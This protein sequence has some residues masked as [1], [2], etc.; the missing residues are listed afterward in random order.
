MTG[1]VRTD[2]LDMPTVKSII[3]ESPGSA[4]NLSFFRADKAISI[5]KITA[6]LRGSNTP[7]VTYSIKHGSDRSGAGTE[8]VTGGS[9]VTSTTTGTSVTSF[10]NASITAGHYVWLVTTAKSGTVDELS[11]TLEF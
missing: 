2:Q 4:E 3:V 9:T 7:S 6:V 11:V 1:G 5:S 10:N 8:V